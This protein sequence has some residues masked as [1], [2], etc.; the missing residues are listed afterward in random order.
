MTLFPCAVQ[1][2]LVAYLFYTQS[3]VSLNLLSLSCRSPFFF[4]TGNHQLVLYI[5]TEFLQ[6]EENLAY[7]LFLNIMKF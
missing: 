6:N 4:P 7:T 5:C 3:L 1:Y 2:I